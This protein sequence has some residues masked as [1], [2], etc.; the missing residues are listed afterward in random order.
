MATNNTKTDRRAARDDERG[1][2]W[3]NA[4][5]VAERKLA[6]NAARFIFRRPC[7]AAEAWA[8]HKA[9]RL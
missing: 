2:R 1:M 9:G 7:S 6:L 3:W 8:L 4:M 5:S